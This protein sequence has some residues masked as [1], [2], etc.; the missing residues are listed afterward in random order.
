MK[1]MLWGLR[2]GKP[3]FLLRGRGGDFQLGGGILCP[4]RCQVSKHHRGPR[5]AEIG[6]SHASTHTWQKS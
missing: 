6:W 3:S 5:K 4:G 1:L 2:R